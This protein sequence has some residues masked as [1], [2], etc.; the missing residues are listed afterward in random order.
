MVTDLEVSN[1]TPQFEQRF[2]S[3]AAAGDDHHNPIFRLLSDCDVLISGG[4]CHNAFKRLN[5]M[6]L[7]VFLTRET[8]IHTALEAY[9]RGELVSETELVTAGH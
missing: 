3:L 9:R 1:P 4:M 7:E 6:G 8:D 2:K 5:D